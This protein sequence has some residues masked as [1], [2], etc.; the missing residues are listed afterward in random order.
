MRS[1]TTGT[2]KTALPNVRTTSVRPSCVQSSTATPSGMRAGASDVGE[3]GSFRRRGGHF[4]HLEE[5]LLPA[6]HEV[7]QAHRAAPSAER[8]ERHAA[9]V[10]RPGGVGVERGIERQARRDAGVHIDHPDVRVAGVRVDAL[11][12]RAR[13]ARRQ[14]DLLVVRR[15]ADDADM[16]AVAGRSRRA[17]CRGCCRRDRRASPRPTPRRRRRRSDRRSAPP[18]RAARACRRR[19][20]APSASAAG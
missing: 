17:G 1:P 11:H 6:G 9:L 18:I 13:S 4:R 5:R 19:I 14:H 10:G 8:R 20:A 15:R 7:A 2:A 3:P 16:P 12:R